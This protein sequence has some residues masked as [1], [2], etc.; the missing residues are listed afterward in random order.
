MPHQQIPRRRQDRTIIVDFQ[1]EATYFALLTQG[2]AFV[3]FVVAFILSIGFQ[4]RH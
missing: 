1:Q 2:K 4:L 3:D